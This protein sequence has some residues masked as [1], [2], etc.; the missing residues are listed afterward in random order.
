VSLARAVINRSHQGGAKRRRTARWARLASAASAA[1]LAATTLAGPATAAGTPTDG[2]G[3][4]TFQTVDN[5]KDTTFNQLLGIN[6]SGVISGYF[7]SG[8]SGH[9]N[10]GYVVAPGYGQG[11]FQ[12]ENFPGA[13]QTQVVGIDNAGVTVGFWVDANGANHGFYAL[14]RKHF[15]TVDFPTSSNA[16]PQVDQLLAVNDAGVAVGF[17]TDGKGV[18]HG[19]SYSILNHRYRS[20]NISGD[21]NVTTAGVNNLKDV[22]GFADNSAGSTEAFL[23]RSDGKLFRLSFP[24]ATATQAFGVNDGDEVVGDYV[25]GSGNTA[26][27]HGFVWSPG[28]G[29]QT[30]N[31]PN[32]TGSTTLNGVNDRGSLVGFYT[33]SAGNTDGLVAKATP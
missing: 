2:S 33:D 12:N 32:G 28:L 8:Q 13:A 29:F 26:T 11:K 14:N 9:P 20:I 18:N 7:G 10:R 5:H 4:Y 19:Y 22:V 21:S 24:G 23:K 15:H 3:N 27:T 17:Y 25:D 31:D 1:A 16:K 30:V 6:N